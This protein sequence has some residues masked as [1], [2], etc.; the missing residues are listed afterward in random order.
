MI[1]FTL[2]ATFWLFLIV[3]PY[4]VNGQCSNPVFHEIGNDTINGVVVTV[5]SS[6]SASLGGTCLNEIYY[7]IGVV[8]IGSYTFEF[9]PPID[10]LILNFFAIN[11][12][13]ISKEIVSIEVNNNH[14]FIPQISDHHECSDSLAVITASGDLT[15]VPYFDVP[16]GG[17][18]T[19]LIIPGTID[20][21]TISNSV[22]SGA[23]NGSLFNLSICTGVASINSSSELSTIDVFPI[24]ADVELTITAPNNMVL[25]LKLFDALGKRHAIYPIENGDQTQIDITEL[26]NGIYFL[27]IE[28]ET[29]LIT[30]KVIINN[31]YR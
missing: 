1:N 27:V 31:A 18:C 26:P 23:P 19:D 5:S 3:S 10:S 4:F 22:I 7:Y 14:Y 6:G 2:K 13:P 24:P 28:T 30:K 8:G 20:K 9:S 29:S 16:F 25:N 21:I 17:G 12:G 15:G 11:G